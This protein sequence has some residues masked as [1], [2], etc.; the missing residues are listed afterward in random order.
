MSLPSLRTTNRQLL[1]SVI[2]GCMETESYLR[3]A[4]QVCFAENNRQG[5]SARGGAGPGG[6]IT[7]CGPRERRAPCEIGLARSR[8][9]L[10][11]RALL[12]AS[13]TSACDMARST[14]CAS[15]AIEAGWA[16][17][18]RRKGGC[19]CA[20]ITCATSATVST[21][22]LTAESSGGEGICSLEDS[23]PGGRPGRNP[24]RGKRSAEIGA[25]EAPSTPP[26]TKFQRGRIRGDGP[27]S[28]ESTRFAF[29]SL[30][31]FSPDSKGEPQVFG[32][33]W[34]CSAA[35]HVRRLN[36]AVGEFFYPHLLDHPREDASHPTRLDPIRL[37]LPQ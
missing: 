4:P 27:C 34:A 2:V 24:R 3:R 5:L 11:Q 25:V 8:L 14:L 20:S 28:L 21:P 31:L 33:L 35:V 22:G 7:R 26:R 36:L 10:Y 15:V 13:S 16:S 9:G 32:P 19:N 29:C 17:P 12:P 37:G 18:G 6:G 1:R 30:Y 23:I